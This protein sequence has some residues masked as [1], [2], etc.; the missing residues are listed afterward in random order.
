MQ[1]VEQMLKTGAKLCVYDPKAMANAKKFLGDKVSYSVSELDA[2]KDAD[3]VAVLTEWPEFAE[4]NL[5]ELK[6][7]MK[8][9]KIVDLRNM[10]KAKHPQDAGFEYQCIGLCK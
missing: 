3:V 2:A 1:I 8:T 4:V 6:A 7:I 5:T 9:P 10:L